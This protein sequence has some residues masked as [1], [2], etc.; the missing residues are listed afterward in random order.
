AS[1][2]VTR[3][4]VLSR[5]DVLAARAFGAS[6]HYEKIIARVYFEIDPRDTHNRQIVDIDKA[7][8]N[9]R[10]KVEFSAD[11][12]LL[13]PKDMNRGNNAVLMEI[14]N[15][16][17]KALLRFF[18]R[19]RSS[20][21]PSTEAEF[22]DGFLMN[23][24]FTLCWLGWQFDVPNAESAM[25]LYPPVATDNGKV[26][27][28][29]VRADFV[30]NSKVYDASLGH[31]GQNAYPVIDPENQDYVL[32]VRDTVLG[33]RKKVARSEWLFARVVNGNPVPDSTYI[34]LKSGFEP[35]KIYELVYRAQN[36]VVVGTGLAAARDLISFF[37]YQPSALVSVRRA[38]GFG[39]SQTG[40][41]L[42]HFLYEGFNADER[43]RQVFDGIDAHV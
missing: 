3:I 38:Y 21:D 10:G 6:G 34:Y 4:E 20:S 7:P 23:Q 26:I 43:N 14:P 18:N 24:G 19:A 1:A 33:E 40:R 2:K 5:S 8:R 16:G 15:R 13:K 36:P 27:T 28:G 35:G 37:K 41:F 17:G 42:R 31:R 11:L 9:A 30:F 25:R 29:L 32:T 12:Y 22:G 39:I